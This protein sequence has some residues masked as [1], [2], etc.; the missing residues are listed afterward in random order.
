MSNL[1]TP[2]TDTGSQCDSKITKIQTK[3]DKQMKTTLDL[4]HFGARLIESK[5]KIENI[6]QTEKTTKEHRQ[7]SHV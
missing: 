3:K 2:S 5:S 1:V 7:S 6:L 4:K